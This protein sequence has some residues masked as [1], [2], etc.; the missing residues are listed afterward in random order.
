MSLEANPA[1]SPAAAPPVAAPAVATA[2]SPAPPPVAVAPPPPAAPA[3]LPPAAV[4]APHPAPV[5]PSMVSIPMEQLQAF[6]TIQTRLAEIED[7]QRREASEAQRREAELL[8]ERGNLQEG[9]RQLREQSEQALAAERERAATIQRQAQGYAIDTEVARALAAHTFVSPV[10]RANFEAEVRRELTADPQ[11]NGFLVR[12]P[13]YQ[14][15]TD[16]VN[17]RLA[18][19]DYQ[20]LLAPRNPQGGTAN[21]GQPTQNAPPPAAAPASP[22]PV[23]KPQNLGHALILQHRDNL[24]NRVAGGDPRYDAGRPFGLTGSS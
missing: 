16:L 22:P 18:H 8:A 9:L 21:P 12:T 1:A 20:F 11:G 19:P 7:R 3:Y 17:A 14:S 5:G 13:T 10:A 6:T 2:T 23:E 4:P 15:A 24:S